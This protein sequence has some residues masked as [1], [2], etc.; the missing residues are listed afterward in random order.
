M[1]FRVLLPLSTYPDSTPDTAFEGMAALAAALGADVTAVVHNADIPQLYNP[2]AEFILKLEAA[3]EAA[4]ALSRAKGLALSK[5]LE[6][7][8]H[9]A[10]VTLAVETFKSERPAGEKVAA[11]ARSFDLTMMACQTGSPD[12]ALLLEEVLFGSGAPVMLFPEDASSMSLD[13]VAVAWDGGRA[14]ARALRDALAILARARRVRLLTC[15]DDK[16]ISRG[17]IEEITTFLS[18]HEI[19]VE[20]VPVGLDGKAIGD[21][22]QSAALAQNANLLVMGAYGHSRVRE[23]ILGGATA[24]VIRAPRLPILLSH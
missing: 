8:C 15:A 23:F 5:R 22:L 2:A 17:S 7:L 13:V 19:V 18:S 14:A 21:A 10:N 24:S 4:E 6:L 1:T 12:H 20:H 11:K 16:P 3:S 9:Q